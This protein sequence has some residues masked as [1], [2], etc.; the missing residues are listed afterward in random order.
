MKFLTIGQNVRLVCVQFD[1]GI[2]WILDKKI[3]NLYNKQQ[4]ASANKKKK[5]E[6]K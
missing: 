1:R 2:I 6:I 4:Q 3:M 5:K